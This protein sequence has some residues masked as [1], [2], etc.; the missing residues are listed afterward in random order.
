MYIKENDTEKTPSVTKIFNLDLQIDKNII[1]NVTFRDEK[2]EKIYQENKINEIFVDKDVIIILGWFCTLI[3]VIFYYYHPLTLTLCLIFT[4]LSF[5][6]VLK[7]KNYKSR[8]NKI[9]F[10]QIFLFSF[11][12]NLKCLLVN[13]YFIQEEQNKKEEIVRILIY[14]FVTFNLFDF[15]L[16]EESIIPRLLFLSTNILSATFSHFYRSDNIFHIDAITST[17]Y[18][19][20]FYLIK[21]SWEYHLRNL[22]SKSYVLNKSLLYSNEFICETNGIHITRNKDTISESGNREFQETFYKYFNINDQNYDTNFLEK[23]K[24]L[25][26]LEQSEGLKTFLN[27][28][29]KYTTETY[30]N[31]KDPQM[32]I[33]PDSVK[34]DYINK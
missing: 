20:I 31:N 14:D 29:I 22:F 32:L 30:N 3:Y 8:S 24:F 6:L 28:M 23:N 16:L 2:L 17:I 5:I 1:S 10:F 11:F 26:F 18:S 15:L 27:S 9:N 21:K 4:S 12:Q 13:V 34:V 25:I 33:L 19:L 7:Q